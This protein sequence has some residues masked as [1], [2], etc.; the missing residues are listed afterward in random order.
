M[1]TFASELGPHVGKLTRQ[2][3]VYADANVPAGVIRYLRER[4]DWDVLAVVE[5]D[6]LRRA[7]DIKHYR[8]ARQLRR[9]VISLDEDFLDSGRFPPNESPG[10]IVLS[11]PDERGLIRLLQT[12]DR[13]FFRDRKGR[14]NT[15]VEPPL[16]GQILHVHPDWAAARSPNDGR[17]RRRRQRRRSGP[18]GSRKP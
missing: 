14:G 16:I 5:H 18:K 1:G 12:V 2:P 8:L 10:V 11:A 13:A 9:S 17:R 3:R 7:S 4:L 15:A 6:E